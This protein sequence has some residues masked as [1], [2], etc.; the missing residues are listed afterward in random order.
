MLT[1]LDPRCH[2]DSGILSHTYTTYIKGVLGLGGGVKAKE[3][4]T[5]LTKKTTLQDGCFFIVHQL[6]KYIYS[7]AYLS[8]TVYFQY[9]LLKW[10]V[11]LTLKK[12]HPKRNR[13]IRKENSA[14]VKI[15]DEVETS[16]FNIVSKGSKKI[17]LV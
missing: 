13:V 3:D 7:V 15:S 11:Q 17:T 1:P 8:F 5:H 16:L 6:Y 2:L 12:S 9:M 4:I 14:V 10:Q